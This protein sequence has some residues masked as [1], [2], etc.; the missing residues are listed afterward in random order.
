MIFVMLLLAS[1]AIPVI[2]HASEKQAK[3]IV[4]SLYSNDKETLSDEFKN[5]KIKADVVESTIQQMKIKDDVKKQLLD[6]IVL[7]KTMQDIH[8][9]IQGAYQ[10]DIR[11]PKT[12]LTQDYIDGIVKD[13]D[14]LRGIGKNVFADSYNESVE[15]LKLNFKINQSIDIMTGN[16]SAHNKTETQQQTESSTATTST[17][18]ETDDYNYT[19]DR[20]RQAEYGDS[21]NHDE[22]GSGD[23]SASGEYYDRQDTNEIDWGERNYSESGDSYSQNFTVDDYNG[24]S[25]E[26]VDGFTGPENIGW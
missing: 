15:E 8:N 1:I 12:D 6:Q 4:E 3:N 13:L 10:S 26:G 7:A 20:S 9:K 19:T 21:S 24:G 5:G 23:N 11:T 22:S 18:T 16:L 14:H 2:G 25:V 17:Q